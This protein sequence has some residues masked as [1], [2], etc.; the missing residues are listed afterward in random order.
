M[1]FIRICAYLIAVI[2]A[3]SPA[4]AKNETLAERG[5]RM[6]EEAGV[7]L[8]DCTILPPELR[9]DG[10]NSNVAAATP[11]PRPLGL[12]NPAPAAFGTGKYGWCDD[13]TSLLAA[14]PVTPWESF[15]G[16]SFQSE[17]DDN[18]R[19]TASLDNS[20][21]GG[22]PGDGDSGNGDAGDGGDTNGDGNGGDGGNGD[23]SE[24]GEVCD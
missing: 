2:V 7:P 24:G 20:A 17:R 4:L 3:S 18:E 13:C 21:P 8:E 11:V 12:D 9:G 23:G 16:R 1:S 22:D 19:Q 5:K 14:A 6:C 10:A 15:G